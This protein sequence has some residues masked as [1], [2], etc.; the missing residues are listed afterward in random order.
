MEN[1][2]RRVS[3]WFAQHSDMLMDGMETRMAA[4]ISDMRTAP[5]L[6]IGNADHVETPLDFSPTRL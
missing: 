4:E 2:L 1:R 3:E 6:V 5:G